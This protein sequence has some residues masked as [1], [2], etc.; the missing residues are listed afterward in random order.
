[1]EWGHSHIRI[2]LTLH[3]H[4]HECVCVCVHVC[5][6]AYMRACM[7]VCVCVCVCIVYQQWGPHG[8]REVS[9]GVLSHQLHCPAEA[10]EHQLT[11]EGLVTELG[12]GGSE[13]LRS[14]DSHMMRDIMVM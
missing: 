10:L 13:E 8:S 14:R 11:G 3:A 4:T 9:P 6:C 2:A 7:C 12:Q 5:V 1:M